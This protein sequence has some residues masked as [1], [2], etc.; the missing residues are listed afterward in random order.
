MVSIEKLKIKN[1]PA[2]LWGYKSN[3]LIIAVHGSH[4]SKIDDCIYILAEEATKYGYQ[5]ISFDLPKHGERIYETKPCMVQNCVKEL[6]IIMDYAKQMAEQIYLFGCSMGAYFSLLA[7]K[8]EKISHTWFLSPVTDM[9]QVVYSIMEQVGVT[10]EQLQKEKII[11]NPIEPL[12]WDYYCYVKENPITKWN[13][14]TSILRGE[15]DTLCEYKFVSDFAKRFKCK[16]EEQ[17]N[18][19]HWFHTEEELEYY[20]EWLKTELKSNN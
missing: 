10:T 6:A 17:K 15:Y 7:Y 2:I 19:E 1:I 4:S 20:R 16:L 18:G 14:N 8:S 12:Y 13:S 9:E 11:N 3:K 5:V